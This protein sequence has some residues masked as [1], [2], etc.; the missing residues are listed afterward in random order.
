[1]GGYNSS[2]TWH[3]QRLMRDDKIHFTKE[4]YILKGSLFV[5]AFLQAWGKNLDKR[6]AKN[7]FNPIAY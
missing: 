5:E 7:I 4:G 3:N 1:M 6:L 2:E